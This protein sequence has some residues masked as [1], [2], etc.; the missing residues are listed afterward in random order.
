VS[1]M[2]IQC[3]R[4]M[5]RICGNNQENEETNVYS[6]FVINKLQK[7]TGTPFGEHLTRAHSMDQAP[8]K[9][10]LTSP[11]KADLKMIIE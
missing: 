1:Q 6:H 5:A 4:Y 3:Y 8:K 11:S 7:E 9:L 10:A 2:E